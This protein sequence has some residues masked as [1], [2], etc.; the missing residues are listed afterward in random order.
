MDQTPSGAI[1]CSSSTGVLM[2]YPKE[3]FSGSFS[4]ITSRKGVIESSD[5]SPDRLLSPRRPLGFHVCIVKVN[6]SEKLALLIGYADNRPY[7]AVASLWQNSLSPGVRESYAVA[8]SQGDFVFGRRGKSIQQISWFPGNDP[9]YFGVLSGNCF[10]LY[11]AHSIGF[12]Y[13]TYRLHLCDIKSDV[14]G[15]ERGNATAFCF[16]ENSTNWNAFAVGFLRNDGAVFVL[17]PVV[18]PGI[19][20]LKSDAWKLVSGTVPE[21]VVNWHRAVFSRTLLKAKDNGSS[22]AVIETRALPEGWNTIPAL[23]GPIHSNSNTE[24]K[25]RGFQSM[26]NLSDQKSVII[27][28][29]NGKVFYYSLSEVYPSFQNASVPSTAPHIIVQFDCFQSQSYS[30]LRLIRNVNLSCTSKNNVQ[31]QKTGDENTIAIV[32]NASVSTLWVPSLS[33]SSLEPLISF[34]EMRD[35]DLGCGWTGNVLFSCEVNDKLQ[36]RCRLLD[37]SSK[38]SEMSSN[39][40]SLDVLVQNLETESNQ[41]DIEEI[42]LQK[43][44]MLR[45]QV[46]N[47]RDKF[48]EIWQNQD[49]IS[50]DKSLEISEM[51]TKFD[52]LLNDVMLPDQQSMLPELAQKYRELL[53][54]ILTSQSNVDISGGAMS[55]ISEFKEWI[56]SDIYS[57]TLCSNDI[58]SQELITQI[59]KQKEVCQKIIQSKERMVL[60]MMNYVSRKDDD[61]IKLLKSQ[62]EEFNVLLEKLNQQ[63]TEMTTAYKNE[64]KEMEKA[65]EQDRS[66]LLEENHKVLKQLDDKRNDLE[67]KHIDNYLQTVQNY[68]DLL[69]EIRAKDIDEYN[70]LK[71]KLELDIQSLEQHLE[72]MRATYQLNAEK[73]EYNYHVLLERDLENSTTINQ[74]KRKIAKQRDLLYTL[75]AKH[76][77][78][79]KSFSDNNSKLKDEYKRITEHFKELQLKFQ[80][81]EDSELAKFQAVWRLKEDQVFALV[82]KLLDADQVIQ[83]QLLG[84]IWFPPNESIFKF[85][86]KSYGNE[87]RSTLDSSILGDSKDDGLD[88]EVRQVIDSGSYHSILELICDETGFLLDEKAWNVI[89]SVPHNE[90]GYVKAEEVVQALG[91]RD[92]SAFEALVDAMMTDNKSEE[93]S[94]STGNGIKHLDLQG[95]D[96]LVHPNEVLRRLKAFIEAEISPTVAMTSKSTKKAKKKKS[97]GLSQ[98]VLKKASQ[99]WE[100]LSNSVNAKTFRVWKVLHEYLDEHHATLRERSTIIQETKQLKEQNSKMKRLLDQYLS[101]KLNEELVISPIH[102]L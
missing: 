53:S 60:E 5:L 47:A 8:S 15:M 43:V 86:P 16:F 49:Q 33:D 63:D 18:I 100:R 34:S 10:A 81:I 25:D 85:D 94:D 39:L 98:R 66:E 65:L 73:L 62:S 13:A 64:L 26:L 1:W 96:D 57:L 90:R 71:T 89:N 52:N 101:S 19:L 75:K 20:F 97:H 22:D 24:C 95:G 74:Q 44:A 27:A 36:M 45:E 12:P 50:S 9:S 87:A 42:S 51:C 17:C 99:F 79:E 72:T 55:G 91:V 11:N 6:T 41:V 84:W 21:I 28:S 92:L 58:H 68:E 30:E 67:Q 76:T 83:E 77:A 59:D 40:P 37:G 38:F 88:D 23:Q 31:I 61:Y 46:K 70:T 102:T 54:G 2:R 93:I 78:L 29:V 35:S 48:F 82:K 32:S 56:E 4:I 14:S 80:T 7:I 3:L 69:K